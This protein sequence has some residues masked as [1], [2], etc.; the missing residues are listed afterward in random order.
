MDQFVPKTF[1][2]N[3]DNENFPNQL[4]QY[5]DLFL[6]IE[7][8][9]GLKNIWLLKPNDLNRGRGIQLFNDIS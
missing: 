1:V 2:L 4:T 6:K 9:G 7:S 3:V 5:L 8:S